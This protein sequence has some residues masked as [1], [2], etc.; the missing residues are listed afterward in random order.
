MKTI[1]MN[2]MKII[3]VKNYEEMSQKAAKLVEAQVLVKRNSV[4]GLATGSTPEGMYQELAKKYRNDEVDFKDVVAFNLDEYYPISADNDQSYAHYM[5]E[6]FFQH[7][8]IQEN[9]RNIPDGLNKDVQASCRAYD[10]ALEAAGNVDLQILGI[11]T[12]GHIGFNEPDEHFAVGTHLVDLNE[13]TIQDNARFF[14]HIDEVPKQAL[15]MGV[16]SIMHAKKIVL[17][18][19]GKNKAEAIRAMVKGPV[20]PELPASILQM[21]QDITLIIDEEAASEL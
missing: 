13:K 4:L 7:V 19:S 15:S 12:N 2:N 1:D 6:H 16:G 3:K 14:E 11:G 17:L 10:R 8:N 21:H 9:N 18:A 20:T 5:R